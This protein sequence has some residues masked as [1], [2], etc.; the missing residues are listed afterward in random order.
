MSEQTLPA[1]LPPSAN[2]SANLV[3]FQ[4]EG[5]TREPQ[6]EAQVQTLLRSSRHS[7]WALARQSDRKA[8]DWVQEETLVC[9]LR[10]WNRSDNRADKEGAWDIA[11]LLIERSA[12]FVNQ[13]VSCWKLSPQHLDDC[14]RDVQVQMLQDLFNTSRGCEFW[15]IRFWL[16]L[17]R[18]LLN[19]VRKYRGIAEAEFVPNPIEDAEGHTTDYFDNITTSD[20]ISPQD[21]AEVREA[22]R[23]LPEQERRAFVLYHYEDWSQ[24][25]I[26][27][28]L[29]VTDRTVRNFLTRAQKRL[30]AW[31]AETSP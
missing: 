19:I 11:E 15:E 18:R 20:A 23:L 30:E 28:A 2:I 9:M 6:V 13:H 25:Q 3:G 24:E 4:T 5:R 8:G 1:P 17:K 7:F 29:E 10:V 26:A 12:R 27:A 16:C 14:K 31:R 21:H 22:L